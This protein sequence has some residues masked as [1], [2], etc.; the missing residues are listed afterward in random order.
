ME[1]K[2]FEEMRNQIAI[3]KGKLDNQEIV[4]E[5]IIRNAVK[6]DADR[7]KSK[8]LIAIVCAIFVIISAPYS[9]HYV[10]GTSYEFVI[11]TDIAMLYC[12]IREYMF[13][14]RVSDKELM[15]SS[16]LEVAKKMSAFKKDYKTYT[17]QNMVVFMPLWIAWLMYENFKVHTGEFAMI[18][19]VSMSIGA[20]IGV[21]IGLR[22]YFRI[23][24][25]ASDI[26][27]QIEE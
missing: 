21:I 15:N 5:R 10:M 25:A 11:F 6:K 14:H 18:N 27:R 23:Q 2:N 17:F 13:K 26:I 7:I 16:L 1:D 20:V 4:N 9:F 22:M 19:T 12:M 3:L 24:D 8:M